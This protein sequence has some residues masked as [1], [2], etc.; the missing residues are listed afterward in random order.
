M[1]NCARVWKVNIGDLFPFSNIN[2]LSFGDCKRA[3]FTFNNFLKTL[4]IRPNALK[5]LSYF[6]NFAN[7]FTMI[8]KIGHQ[9]FH[10]PM[11]CCSRAQLYQQLS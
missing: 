6:S 11:N 10:S 5:K 7:I 4:F 8:I 9:H 3:R 1:L 2:K